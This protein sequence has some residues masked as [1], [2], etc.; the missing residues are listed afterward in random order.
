MKYEKSIAHYIEVELGLDINDV[1]NWEKN[2]ELGINPYEMTKQSNKMIWV[3]CLKHDYHNYDRE[4]NKIGYRVRCSHFNNG[5]R[6][7]YCGNY[8][9][10]YKDSLGFLYPHIAKKIVA[11]EE[12][13]LTFEDTYSIAVYKNERY[14]FKCLECGTISEKRILNSVTRQGFSCKICSDGLP[15][16]EKFMANI[17]KQ[18]GIEYVCQLSKVNFDWCEDYKYDFYIPSL[19][20]IIETHGEQHY[21]ETHEKSAWKSNLKEQQENDKNKEKLAKENNIEKYIIVDCRKSTL[22]WLKSNIIKSLSNI[23]DLNNVD[24]TVAYE[25]SQKSKVVES[26]KLWNNGIHDTNEIGKLLELN[27]STITRYLQMG[28]ECGKCDYTVEESRKSGVK[29]RSGKNHPGARSI[30]C[31]TTNK[32]FDTVTEAEEFYKEFGCSRSNIEKVCKGSRKSCGKL[33]NGTKLTWKFLED[34]LAEN[35]N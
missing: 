28:V 17:L 18:L 16:T 10:H 25:Q 6:C 31:I 23:F 5:V 35:K 11:V 3:Y 29:K 27:Q 22:E 2:N 33:E 8:K 26:W 4:G 24:Y 14:Y 32:I 12:N 9:T 30:I 7:G 13:N 1:W 34:Y 19:N 20:M 21:K 15:I